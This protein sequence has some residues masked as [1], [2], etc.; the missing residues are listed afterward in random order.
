MNISCM[1]LTVGV[2]PRQC[3]LKIKFPQMPL[4]NLTFR[5]I[6]HEIRAFGTSQPPIQ[7]EYGLKVPQF[8]GFRGPMGVSRYDKIFRQQYQ[9][10]GI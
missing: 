7:N 9:D 3:L 5:N 2:D 10:W 4:V 6:S 8:G 1:P